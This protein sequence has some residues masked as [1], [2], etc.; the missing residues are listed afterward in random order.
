MIRWGRGVVLALMIVASVGLIWGTPAGATIRVVSE[1]T[2][3][4][5]VEP[6]GVY[7]GSITLENSGDRVETARIYQTDYLF[8]ADG[9][10]QF[11]EPGSV[12]RSNAAWIELGLSEAVVPPRERMTVAFRLRVPDEPALT[13]TY[14]SVI[15][16]EPQSVSGGQDGSEGAQVAI[17]QTIRYAIQIVT[18]MIQAPGVVAIDFANPKLQ[19]TEAGYVFQIDIVNQGERWFVPTVWMELFHG[20]GSPVGRFESSQRRTYPGT[21]A[22]WT[23]ELG[24]LEPGTYEAI[25]IADGGNDEVYGAQYTLAVPE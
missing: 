14:W 1:L 3:V 9:Y 15:M 24:T 4:Y 12:E 21:S 25:V 13:G 22:R 5:E 10:S 20:D 8:G 19:R 6:G 23:I 17:R 11:D 16:V 7:E 18:H 2:R